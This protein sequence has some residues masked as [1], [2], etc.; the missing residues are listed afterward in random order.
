VSEPA[1]AERTLVHT[2]FIS[3]ESNDIF[4]SDAVALICLVPL[5]RLQTRGLQSPKAA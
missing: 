3:L 2:R 5:A 4:D 1:D